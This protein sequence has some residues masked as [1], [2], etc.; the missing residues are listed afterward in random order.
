M[1]TT[2]RS[3]QLKV[4]ANGLHESFSLRIG[5]FGD[6]VQRAEAGLESLQDRRRQARDWPAVHR[7]HE[8]ANI[9]C[10]VAGRKRFGERVENLQ[11]ALLI[12]AVGRSLRGSDT[13]AITN[14]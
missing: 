1:R 8:P 6:S 2:V 10:R 4:G 9:A 14:A 13:Q 3:L 11:R 7:L 5:Q 12:L